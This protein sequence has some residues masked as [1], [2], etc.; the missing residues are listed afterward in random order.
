MRRAS[1]RAAVVAAACVGS[2]A[3][4]SVAPAQA[5]G[6]SA[7]ALST[8]MTGAA[9]VPGPGDADGI[10]VFAAVTKRNTLCYLVTAH[11]IEPAMAAHIHA[12]TSDVAG[13]IVV[14][15]KP[16]THGFAA[17]CIR[18]LPDTQNTT[19]T[20]TVSELAAIRANPNQYYVNIHNDPFMAGAIRGQLR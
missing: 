11:R 14:G 2:V 4:L 15:L 10:G 18:T 9:E 16:P 3:A 6:R 13:G 19:E 17:D 8:V 1:V 5:T 20:L 7:Q 12:G